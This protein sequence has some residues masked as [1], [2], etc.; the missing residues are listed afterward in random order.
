MDR[1][2]RSAY[3]H[4]DAVFA[5]IG[6]N[7][8]NLPIHANISVGVSMIAQTGRY[9]ALDGLEHFYILEVCLQAC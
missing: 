8:S 1:F 2:S 3:K 4:P 5:V 9:D 7:V 6:K